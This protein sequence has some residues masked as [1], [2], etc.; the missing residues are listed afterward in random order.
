[1][2]ENICEGLR[3]HYSTY[4]D[5]IFEYNGADSAGRATTARNRLD[6]GCGGRLFCK[7]RPFQGQTLNVPWSCDEVSGPVKFFSFISSMGGLSLIGTRLVPYGYAYLDP[8]P[9]LLYLPQLN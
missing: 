4:G 3:R 1:M 6:A 5:N 2:F 9:T 8:I 7:A